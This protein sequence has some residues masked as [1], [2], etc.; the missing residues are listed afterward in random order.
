MLLRSPATQAV[1]G[2]S[3]TGAPSLASSRGLT[4]TVDA[5][6]LSILVCPQDHG[7]LVYLESEDT[8]YN[9]RLRCRYPIEDGIVTM[10]VE[11]AVTVDDAEHDRLLALSDEHPPTDGGPR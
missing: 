5:T 11:S 7:P 9:P 10:L 4:M 3:F 2:R 1:G 8:L 6:L